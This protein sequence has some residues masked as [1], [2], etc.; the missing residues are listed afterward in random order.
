MAQ[1]R[2]MRSQDGQ[3]PL[4]MSS[5]SEDTRAASVSLSVKS[6]SVTESP[7]A[8][9]KLSGRTGSVSCEEVSFCRQTE[10]GTPHQSKESNGTEVPSS[11]VWTLAVILS[12]WTVY[13]L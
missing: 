12:E 10:E 11:T 1:L 8:N 9:V 3:F 6:H 5:L 7:E 13:R 4:S 2:V